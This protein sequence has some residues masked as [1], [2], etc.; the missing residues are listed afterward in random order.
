M[1]PEQTVATRYR[2]LERVAAE[3][4]LCHFFHFDF[5]AL[6]YV[7]PS[8]QAWR[9]HPLEDMDQTASAS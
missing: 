9:W 4:A 5:P 1:D 6:G 3:G 2:I 8:G 7:R